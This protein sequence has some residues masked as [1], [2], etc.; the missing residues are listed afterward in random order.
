MVRPTDGDE[1]DR[2]V[3]V[4]CNPLLSSNFAHL[5]GDFRFTRHDMR[6]RHIGDLVEVRSDYHAVFQCFLGGGPDG[7]T[8]PDVQRHHVHAL[9]DG[10]V[11]VRS[12]DGSIRLTIEYLHIGAVLLLGVIRCPGGVGLMEAI[13]HRRY[14]VANLQ[15]FGDLNL[16]V[17]RKCS[18]SNRENQ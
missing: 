7:L 15:A 12:H 18:A 9:R 3:G 2:L 17:L 6:N 5:F 14:E 10:L 4:S 16:G 1:H 8:L 11:E 13:V